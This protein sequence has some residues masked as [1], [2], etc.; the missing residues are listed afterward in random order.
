MGCYLRGS[1]FP[2][3]ETVAHQPG[4]QGWECRVC[5]PAACRRGG[6]RS[7]GPPL[8]P[9]RSTSVLCFSVP[10][11]LCASAH[12][13]Q[14]VSVPHL[15]L[16]LPVCVSLSLPPSLPSCLKTASHICLPPGP[17]SDPPSECLTP[18]AH[19]WGNCLL[20]P[21]GTEANYSYGRGPPCG[22][23]ASAGPGL[24]RPRRGEAAEAEAGPPWAWA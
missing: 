20:R 16:C 21:Q 14:S 22:R 15:S 7:P 12:W 18:T 1:R 8:G 4:P 19:L 5:D 17:G 6:G 11:C 9:P 13:S 10:V 3:V 23:T 24:Y 2:R